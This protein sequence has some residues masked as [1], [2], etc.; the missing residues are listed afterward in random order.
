MQGGQEKSSRSGGEMSELKSMKYKRTSGQIQVEEAG[1][2]IKENFHK[3]Y[4]YI[5]MTDGVALGK[6]TTDK[7]E[8]RTRDGV[9]LNTIPWENVQELAVFDDSKELRIR[10]GLTGA[11]RLS[12]RLLSDKEGS[13]ELYVMDEV[14]KLWGSIEASENGWTKLSSARGSRIWVPKIF[15]SGDREEKIVGLKVRKYLDFPKATENQGLTRQED[16]RFVGF[17]GWS[18]A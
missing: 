16:E 12:S 6:Y 5:V 15:C 14:Q 8:I 9:T 2:K 17:C 13:G 11:G 10:K 18:E 4:V 1:K 3:A 7:F